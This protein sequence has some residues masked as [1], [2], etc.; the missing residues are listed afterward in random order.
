VYSYRVSGQGCQYEIFKKNRLILKIIFATG[1]ICF[2]PRLQNN[3]PKG[4]DRDYR[5]DRGSYAENVNRDR[6]IGD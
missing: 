5:F 1:Q 4:F 3:S 6:N 2:S